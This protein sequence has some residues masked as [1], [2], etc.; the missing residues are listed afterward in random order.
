MEN[1]EET[2]KTV[3][4]GLTVGDQSLLNLVNAAY[5]FLYGAATL[6][7]GTP[8]HTYWSAEAFI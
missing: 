3:F 8:S 2:R 6:D 5:Q 1:R 4:C 7:S